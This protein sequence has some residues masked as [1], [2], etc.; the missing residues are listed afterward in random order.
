MDFKKL[1]QKPWAAIAGLAAFTGLLVDFQ[2][3]TSKMGDAIPIL[4]AFLPTIAIS[5]IAVFSSWLVY[6]GLLRI[7]KILPSQRFYSHYA[8]I[9]KCLSLL[10]KSLEKPLSLYDETVRVVGSPAVKDR[11]S[12]Y[13]FSQIERLIPILRKFSIQF[14]DTNVEDHQKYNIE[15]F[16][17][18]VQLTACAEQRDLNRARSITK[19]LGLDK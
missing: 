2:G 1:A 9:D 7:W 10:T 12:P 5:G 16:N 19:R 13:I 14:P 8:Q 18:L 17:F 11:P 6:S 3:A 15:W 4:S